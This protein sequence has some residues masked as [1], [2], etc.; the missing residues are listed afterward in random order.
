MVGSTTVDRR[1]PSDAGPGANRASARARDYDLNVF[2]EGQNV[3]D[4]VLTPETFQRMLRILPDHLKLVV[5]CAYYTALR[6][7]EVLRPI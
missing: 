4:H 6:K 3:Q 5:L 2:L 1:T 7:G